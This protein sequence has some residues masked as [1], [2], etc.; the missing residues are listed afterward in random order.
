MS[1]ST[2]LLP[3]KAI[4][5]PQLSRGS[6]M[7]SIL[8]PQSRQK[9]LTLP[10]LSMRLLLYMIASFIYLNHDCHYPIH[11]SVFLYRWASRMSCCLWN[12][13]VSHLA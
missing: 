2:L 9:C 1:S 4:S 13:I 10:V 3:S 12:V 11:V 8:D 6:S 5:K 7:F